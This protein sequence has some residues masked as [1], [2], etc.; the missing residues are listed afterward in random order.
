VASQILLAPA[1]RNQLITSERISPPPVF[2]VHALAFQFGTKRHGRDPQFPAADLRLGCISLL[3]SSNSSLHDRCEFR[4]EFFEIRM[5]LC[6][7][8]GLSNRGMRP[9]Y[10]LLNDV[11]S[12]P[13]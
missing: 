3:E 4:G 11:R 2:D 10:H 6:A 8:P 7:A 1:A 13:L 12:R 9:L 5:A